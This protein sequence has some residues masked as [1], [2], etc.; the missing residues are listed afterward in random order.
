MPLQMLDLFRRICEKTESTEGTAPDQLYIDSHWTWTTSIRRGSPIISFKYNEYH[1][2][3]ALWSLW[4]GLDHISPTGAGSGFR[5]LCKV[6]GCVNPHHYRYPEGYAQPAR[7][8]VSIESPKPN[9]RSHPKQQPNYSEAEEA[10]IAQEVIESGGVGMSPEEKISY[11]KALYPKTRGFLKA[12][13][14]ENCKEFEPP[15]SE[16]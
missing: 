9:S 2:A 14:P 1:V 7:S 8:T 6:R 12:V 11:W 15:T 10:S 5:R 13:Y 3:L 4:Q 16:Q